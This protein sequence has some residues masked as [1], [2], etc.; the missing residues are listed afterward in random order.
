MR[1]KKNK[2]KD[3]LLVQRIMFLA[4]ASTVAFAPGIAVAQR[5][6]G[7]DV[8]SY[9]GEPG[10]TSVK[11]SGIS[12]AWAKATEGTFDDDPDFA[13]NMSNGKAAGVLMGAYHFAHPASDAPSSESSFFWSAAGGYI[14]ADGKSLQPT[15][16][17]EVFSGVTGAS[18]YSDWANQWFND[19]LNDASGAGVSV[20]PVLYTSSCSACDF[21]S[22]VAKWFDWM[23][24]YNGESAQTGTPWSSCSSCD[25]WGGW[26]VWQ[27]SSSGSVSGISGACDV[28]VFNGTSS[29]LTS[30]LVISNPSGG[31]GSSAAYKGPIAINTDGTLEMFGVTSANNV[32]HEYQNNPNGSWSS[33]FN[34]TGITGVPGVAVAQNADG[35]LEI[36]CVNSSDK[37]VYHNYQ[38]APHSS[39]AGWFSQGGTGITNLVAVTNLDGRLEVFGIGSN[40]DVWHEWQTNAG[41]AWNAWADHPGQHIKAGF[42]VGINGDGRLEIFGVGANGD[43]WHDYQTSPGGAWNGYIDFG[44]NGM[45]PKLAVASNAD[46][47]QELY[48]VGSNGDVWHNYQV[49]GGGGAWNGWGDVGAVGAVGAGAQAGMVVGSN[50]DGRLEVFVATSAGVIWHRYQNV[51]GGSW[52]PWYSLGG[53][54]LDPNLMVANNENGAVQVFG[55]NGNDKT[56]YTNYQTTP[57]GGWNGWFSMGN[58]GIRFFFGQP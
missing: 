13:Y 30:T 33:L 25:V 38:T 1:L 4:A 26:N 46:G 34:L 52:T 51:A 32:A 40:G 27:Y 14:K 39:W 21:D 44:A 10:W 24:N 57:G 43:V 49:I 41:G 56:I 9:Q 7:V 18:S 45:N 23:A 28:D 20:K 58:A 35:R 6:L 2:P 31:S 15:L 54:G 19:I 37:K 22:S 12:F 3:N 42:T 8:S 29:G 48:G 5:P 47:R 53:S 17:F 55:I 16:D 50:P 11:A 36:F